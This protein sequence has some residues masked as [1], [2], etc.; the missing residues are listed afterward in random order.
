MFIREIKKN[1]KGYKKDF[2]Y[3]RLMESYRTKS[4]PRQRTLLNLGTLDLPR[5]QWKSLADTI[6]DKVLGQGSLLKAD[7]HI[8][9]LATH[10]ANL[11]VQKNLVYP[12]DKGNEN[13][14]PE[15]ETIDINSI[16]NS[17]IRTIGAEYVGVSMF[18][19]LELDKL[20]SQLGF[21]K[22][23]IDLA[24]LSIVGRLV[25]PASE[26][27]TRRWAKH[28]SGIDELLD[29][30][31]THL[32]NN[33]LYRILDMQFSYKDKIEDHLRTKERNIF[34]L[35]ENIILYDL[36]NTYFEGASKR[37]KKAKHGKSKEKRYDCPLVTLGMLIDERGFPKKSEIF[38]GNIGEAETLINMLE[39]LSGEKTER[40]SEQKPKKGIT[41]VIDAGIAT[42]ENLTL[43]KTQGYDYISVARNKPIDSS[44]ISED[45]LLIIK[46][47]KNNKVEVHL[48]KQGE[49][50]I[51][52]CKSLLK[53]KKEQ[54]IQTLFQE[55]FEQGLKEI[56]S[57]LSKKGGTK[58]YE[59]VFERIGRLKEKYSA[60]AQY[61]KIDVEHNKGIATKITWSFEKAKKAKERFSGSYFLRTTRTELDEKN[62]W[63]LYVML[64]NIE[65]AFRY[66]K[67]DLN[68]RPIWH[69]KESRV[70]AHIFNTLLAY[71]LLVSLKNQLKPSHSMQWPQIRDILN[72]H[73]RVTTGMTN[74]KGK[75]FFIRKCSDPE[76]FHKSIYNTLGLKHYPIGEKRVK[77]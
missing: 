53:G 40:D 56:G 26:K 48:T 15:Y 50:H 43:L 64:T 10:Y 9:T 20:L 58:K 3:H 36:T 8:E 31:F 28:I 61:Y 59:K 75:R 19:Q 25:Y 6:E 45:D 27:K 42:E 47:G 33:A 39:A 24:A 18:K 67:S 71:H 34:S 12:L 21:T 63:S 4:G 14:E 2:T 62:I 55:R 30:D 77:M 11:L 44:K 16:S 46:E 35:K 38:Q 51:L 66:L 76:E 49:E 52:Y 37:N 72:T 68:I 13:E 5:E 7:K 74:M 22:S 54:A 57:S 69:Q 70:D 32:S 1:N 23:Q 41:V 29:T 60:I 65:D 17:R 73:V